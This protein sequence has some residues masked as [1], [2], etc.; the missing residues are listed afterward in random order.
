MTGP[1]RLQRIL[2]VSILALACSD[3]SGTDGRI[4][5]VDGFLAKVCE[6]AAGCAGIS[7]TP[8]DIADCPLGIR[9]ELSQNQLLELEEFTT[10]TKVQQDHILE[11]IGSAICA[12]FGGSLS[13]I[14]DSDI[15]E[16]YRGCRSSA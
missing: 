15:M 16:P 6:K 3:P 5:T 10:Y 8:G 1:R 2:A 11:C 12:R 13:S 14:S 7:A 9:S 4:G